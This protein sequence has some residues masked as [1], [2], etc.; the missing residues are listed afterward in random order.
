MTTKKAPA[1]VEVARRIAAGR[2]PIEGELDFVLVGRAL[3]A[4]L[5]AGLIRLDHGW[6]PDWGSC[7]VTTAGKAA[8]SKSS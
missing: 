2:S 6:H 1:P 5:D 8:I 4:A 3:Q 7:S